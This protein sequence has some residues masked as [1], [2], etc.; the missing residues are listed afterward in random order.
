MSLAYGVSNLQ[1]SVNAYVPGAPLLVLLGDSAEN[2]VLVHIATHYCTMYIIMTLRR[3]RKCAM[4]MGLSMVW[5]SKL[6]LFE[7]NGGRLR[8]GKSPARN[9]CR[10]FCN[11]LGEVAQLAELAEQHLIRRHHLLPPQRLPETSQCCDSLSLPP[12]RS[13]SQRWWVILRRG[14]AWAQ[15]L[16][17]MPR[18]QL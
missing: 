8:L 16:Q 1:C 17:R 7:G 4:C 15:I 5:I 14:C 13:Q 3:P 9:S 6:L 2:H 11:I 18:Q 12:I 10:K